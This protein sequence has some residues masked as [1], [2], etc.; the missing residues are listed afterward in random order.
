MG[1]LLEFLESTIHLNATLSVVENFVIM[2]GPAFA[3]VGGLKMIVA[4]Y[5]EAIDTLR[6]GLAINNRLFLAIWI[7]CCN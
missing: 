6:K 5:T 1:N 4:N 2:E 3:A 7:H